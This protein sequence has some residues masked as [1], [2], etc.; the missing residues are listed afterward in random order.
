MERAGHSRAARPPGHSLRRQLGRPAAAVAL[1]RRAG[2]RGRGCWT[3]RTGARGPRHPQRPDDRR[4]RAGGGDR[5]ESTCQPH[6]PDRRQGHRSR[7]GGS[8][9][10]LRAGRVAG[11][12]GDGLGP[13]AGWPVG[14]CESARRIA[15][16]TARR[17]SGVGAGDAVNRRGAGLGR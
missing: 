8:G 2:A 16:A 9:G 5:G 17:Q 6:R 15:V 11:R 7:R 14:R 13:G 10:A 3:H 1:A 12:R 4:R